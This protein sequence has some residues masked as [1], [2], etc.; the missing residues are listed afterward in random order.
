MTCFA[1]FIIK[2]D[3]PILYFPQV[4]SVL[5]VADGQLVDPLSIQCKIQVFRNNFSV[6]LIDFKDSDYFDTLRTKMGWGKRG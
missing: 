2:A 1:F 5:F 3:C 4:F 6:N